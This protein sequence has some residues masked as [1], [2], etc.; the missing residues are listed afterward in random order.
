MSNEL[1]V[2]ATHPGVFQ[3]SNCCTTGSQTGITS[4]PFRDLL[5][6]N[7]YRLVTTSKAPVTTS[8]A[9]VSNSFLLLLV[10]HLLLLAWHLFLYLQDSTNS[11][12]YLGFP[13]GF[14]TNS[15]A[16]VE[17]EACDMILQALLDGSGIYIVTRSY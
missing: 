10:R 7:S 1:W 5:S 12:C 17:Q 6:L 9:L 11:F 3:S 16:P 2:A 14:S 8:D 4:S 13:D 15:G